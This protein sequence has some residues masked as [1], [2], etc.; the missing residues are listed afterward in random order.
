[1]CGMALDLGVSDSALSHRLRWLCES[2][3]FTMRKA[4]RIVYFRL[5]D[6]RLRGLVTAA[7]G[8]DPGRDPWLEG[9][10]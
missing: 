7:G 8:E 10:T 2:G 5:A 1:M 6:D 3:A 4:G 9:E